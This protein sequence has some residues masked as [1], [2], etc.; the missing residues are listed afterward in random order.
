MKAVIRAL[1]LSSVALLVLSGNA[2]QAYAIPI[3]TLPGSP[4]TLDSLGLDPFRAAFDE[5]GNGTFQIFNPATNSYGPTQ[6]MFAQ[7]VADPSTATGRALQYT[8]P[9]LVVPGDVAITEPLVTSGCSIGGS[10][11]NC[12]DGLR[13]LTVG[14]TSF[15]RFYSDRAEGEAT[16][17]LADTGLPADFSPSAI[18]AEVGLENGVN[19]FIYI[20]GLSPQS[21]ANSNFYTGISDVPEP[22]TMSL[23]GAALL[24]LGAVLRRRRN[25]A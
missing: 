2:I 17:I 18:A 13:F 16:T 22:G 25:I 6:V 15:M 12:S 21:A 19:A 10:V 23:F 1:L 3:S 20:A 4:L 11:A 7:S 24:G 5:N 8:L 9:Q 14:A